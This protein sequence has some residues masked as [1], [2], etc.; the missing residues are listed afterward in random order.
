MKNKKLVYFLVPL[1]ILVWGLIFYRIFTKIGN[2]DSDRASFNNTITAPDREVKSDTLVLIA[3][4]RD[5]FLSG[6]ARSVKQPTSHS[7]SKPQNTIFQNKPPVLPDIKYLG[8]VSNVKNK[9]K[10]GLF[11][12]QGKNYLLKEGDC[13]GNQMKI[14]KLFKDSLVLMQ[15]HSKYI[16]KRI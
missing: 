10:L 11:T 5:P 7:Y 13:A 8:L 9:S 15:Q 4:Y 14:I 3:D 1:T 2:Q 16:I 12:I 6:V